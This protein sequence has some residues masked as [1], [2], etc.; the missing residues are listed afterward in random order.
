MSSTTKVTQQELLRWKLSDEGERLWSSDTVI[1]AYLKGKKDGLDDHQKA[2]QSVFAKNFE[3]SGKSTAKLFAFLSQQEITPISAHLKIDS[4]FSFEVVV[5]LNEADFLGE[6]MPGVYNWCITLQKE[7]EEESFRICFSF[8]D[9][10]DG[11]DF[12]Q[13]RSDGFR[14]KFQVPSTV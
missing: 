2:L 5:L 4:L 1:D 12:E 13:L 11:F 14:A 10:M 8:I 7:E 9:V 6:K 3:K